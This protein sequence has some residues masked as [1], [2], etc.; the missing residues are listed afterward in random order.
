[1]PCLWDAQAVIQHGIDL[2][3]RAAPVAQAIAGEVVVR[4]RADPR[5]MRRALHAAEAAVADAG[6]PNQP[7]YRGL[8]SREHVVRYALG[9]F[10]T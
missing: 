6:D 2:A 5:P 8:L 1:M 4:L 10:E 7:H 3:K 9:E